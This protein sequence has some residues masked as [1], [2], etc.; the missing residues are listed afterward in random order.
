MIR[1][2]SF[3]FLVTQS[4]L[5]FG[6]NP[7]QVLEANVESG[8]I[9]KNYPRF[10]SRDPSLVLSTLIGKKLLGEEPWHSSYTY[11]DFGIK[12]TAANLGNEDVLGYMFGIMPCI[13]VSLK[14]DHRF[15]YSLSAGIGV[16][17]FTHKYE[18]NTN[19]TNILIGSHFTAS[20]YAGVGISRP[21]SPTLDL[22]LRATVYHA[23]NGHTQ[24]PNV[25]LNM[26]CLNTGIAFRNERKQKDSFTAP[27]IFDQKKIGYNIKL[28]YGFNERGNSTGPVGGKKYDI[29]TTSFS[30]FKR[31]S[32]IGKVAAGCDYTFN[33]NFYQY[34]SDSSYYSGNFTW[35]ASVISVFLSHEFLFGHLGLFTQG[36][37]NIH[38][39]FYRDQ[40]K[41]M[42][43]KEDIRGYLKTLF[44]SR[45]GLNYY[46]KNAYKR[47]KKNIYLGTY[48]KANFGQADFAEFVLGMTF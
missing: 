42:E 30:I 7:I 26:L 5:L 19:E 32:H 20:A 45:I 27:T 22:L 12:L 1:F 40:Y 15:E 28:G 36:G 3:L 11:P 46:I 6:Q 34:I 33:N 13:S 18:I 24:L 29:Y 35:N 4:T 41:A 43:V 10:P 9:V 21:I 31:Y 25:G 39:P 23:S 44:P 16:S 2:L 47:D 48:V 38:N 17:A 8:L 14:S 37:I